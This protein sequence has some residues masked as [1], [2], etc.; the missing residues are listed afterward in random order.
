MIF[1]KWLSLSFYSLKLFPFSEKLIDRVKELKARGVTPCLATILVGDDPSSE[2]YVK[3]KGNACERI[4][5]KSL[6]IHLPK[7]TLTDDLLKVIEVL[8]NPYKREIY[9][10]CRKKSYSR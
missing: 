4:G 6:R 8:S 9:C 5:I 1:R 2:T 3:M 7:D 10:C